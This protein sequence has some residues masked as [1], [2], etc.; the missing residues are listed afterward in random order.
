MSKISLD[1]RAITQRRAD[2]GLALLAAV[3][4]L[5]AC[6]F[7]FAR[8]WPLALDVG[9]NDARFIERVTTQQPNRGFHA[10]EP[11]GGDMSRWT[12]GD[13]TLRLPQPPANAAQLL[14]LRLLNSRPADQPVPRVQL[15]ANGVALGSF[16]VPISSS[17][18][19]QYQVLLPPDA[20]LSW[21]TD[22]NLRSEPISLPGDPRQLGV[23]LD[24]ARIAP[25]GLLLPSPW[26]VLMA[27]GLG[28]MA[29][30]FPRSI[31]LERRWAFGLAIVLGLL[32]A[33]GIAARPLELLPFI[34]RIVVVLALGCL[35]MLLGRAL[36]VSQQPGTV[37]GA[38]VPLLFATMW[39]MA[40]LF[41]AF[42]TADGAEG[43]S[44][45]VPTVWI[46]VV[47]TL[48]LLAMRVWAWVRPDALSQ[49]SFGQ[50]ALGL[51]GVAALAHLVYMLWFAFGRQGPDF[52][53][54]FKG[55][56]DWVRGGSLYD[57][58]AVRTNHFG[59]V[60]KVPPFYGMLFTPFVFQDG[61]RILMFHRIINV[62]LLTTT[63]F[64]WLRLWGLRPLSL[65][66]AA[67]LVVLNFRPI[68]DTLAFGQID[69]ALL[70]SLT[71]A[72]GAL[73]SGRD[74]LAGALIAL[75]TLFKIYPVLLLAFLVAKQNWR[76]LMGFVL[77]M[78]VLNGISIAVMGWEM[79]WIYITQVFPN[80]G[81]TTAQD[82]NQT[83][84]GFMARFV[85][86]PTDASIFQVRAITL[87][88]MAISALLGLLACLVS[89]RSAA[90]RSTT[91][92]L[93]YSQFLLLMVLVAPAA[94]MHYEVLLVI[95]FGVLLLH[96]R[97][98][99]I[100]LPQ[101]AA[102]AIGFALIAYGNQYS[103]YTGT[104]MGILTVIGVSYKFY[105]MLLLGGV[106]L[107]ELVRE[108]ATIELPRWLPLP[109]FARDFLR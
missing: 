64:V 21:A 87:P 9:G 47:L 48:A 56:R 24:A 86:S 53:I 66:G 23:V 7:A 94:W 97:D 32:V 11:F 108:P 84:S 10:V 28:L 83:I 80:I 49:R 29:Y 8:A 105:G 106:M 67:L 96:W 63:A 72:L 99:Q 104:V 25:L 12:S 98:R 81:G 52:W 17:G 31:G 93:Q 65:A 79:H 6:S 16:E 35:G 75:G 90:L 38:D 26:L 89:L 20:R 50:V 4:T 43:V 2:L 57:L 60:F 14:S 5:L 92:A 39:W 44:P 45:P 19:R 40:P 77:G 41:Q 13:A 61:M 55:A 68:A 109:P 18:M 88:A 1:T 30:T 69:L 78:L 58:E 74:V 62:I 102:L 76:A 36:S 33:W 85:A 46:G 103:F 95:P 15:S 73:R 107:S 82:Q 37:R 3:V 27:I 91:Y 101:A 22:L 59:H 71:L 100:P 34:Q 42:I 70:L 51:F 54:L